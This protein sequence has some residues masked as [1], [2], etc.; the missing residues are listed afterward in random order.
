MPSEGPL[1]DWLDASEAWERAYDD[2]L[3]AV[4]VRTP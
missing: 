1:A 4:W 2:P 3:A